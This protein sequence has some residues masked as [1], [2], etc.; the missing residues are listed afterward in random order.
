M[1]TRG[2]ISVCV[3][4][5][6]IFITSSKAQDI[7]QCIA[8]SCGDI[9]EIK[10]PF[11]LRTDPEHC[12]RHGY[13]LDCQ[14]N[15]TVFNYK[16]RIFYVQEINYTSYSIRLLDP[17]LKDQKENCTVFPNHRA[18]YDAMTSQIFEWVR[19]NNDINY[20]NCLAP[21]N[22]SQYIPTRFC[23]KNTTSFSYLVIREVLQASDLAGG[24]RVETVAWSSAPGI[25]SNKT[26][27][28]SST[29]QG[30]AY[31]FEL[32]WKRNML[33]RNCDRSRGGECTIEENSDRATCRYWCKEDIHVSKLTFRCKVQYYSVF[34]LFFGGIGIGGVL[35]LR[36][37][38]GIPI[39]IAAV[40]WQCKRRNLH[41]SSNEQNC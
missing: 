23:S 12:G 15:Q 33:C 9:S 11:R 16:S 18:S 39:L 10:F 14:N 38:L 22:S 8:S 25:S 35:A 30:L 3:F 28:L 7:S 32:S 24:C 19:V 20:V 37:L 31:G 2:L 26:S 17:G 41:T 4:L 36:F 13:E 5:L 34:V 27:T 6:V 29:H 40:V 1:L 21:I